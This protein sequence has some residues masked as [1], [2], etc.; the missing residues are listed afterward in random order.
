MAAG[1]QDTVASAQKEGKVSLYTSLLPVQVERLS[2]AFAKAFPGIELR[3]TRNTENILT[4]KIMQ[5][6]DVAAEGADVLIVTNTDFIDQQIANGKVEKPIGEHVAPFAGTKFLYKDFAPVVAS[7][8]VVVA[9]NADVVKVP[10]A[11]FADLVDA[12]RSDE[13]G[14][15]AVESGSGAALFYDVLRQD[16]PGYWEKLAKKKIKIFPGAVPLSQAVAS[17]EVGIAIY[18]VPP[19]LSPLIKKGAPIKLVSPTDARAVGGSFAAQVL[20]NAKNQ[21]A[22][23]VLVDWM[24]SPDGQQALNG[25]GLG[26]PNSPSVTGGLPPKDFVLLDTKIYTSEKVKAINAEWRGMMGQ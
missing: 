7:Y 15:T 5:E 6:Q 23:Q 11:Q 10:P 12:A 25:D 20:K 24:V 14:L 1:W 19:A 3:V 22:A 13:I 8:Y 26:M 21:A 17:G 18:G 2:A 4:Q 16:L 9:Y